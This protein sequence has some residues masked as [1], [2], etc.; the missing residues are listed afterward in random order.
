MMMTTCLNPA[1]LRLIPLALLTLL[2]AGCTAGNGGFSGGGA[3]ANAPL[4]A[5][6]A[7]SASGDDRARVAENQ[8]AALRRVPGLK[9]DLVSVHDTGRERVVYYGRYQRIQGG[10]D[11]AAGFKPDP[12]NDLELIRSLSTTVNNQPYWPFLYATMEELPTAR[13]APA[14]WDLNNAQ[15]HWSLQVAVFYN[16]EVITSRRELAEAYA[17]ELREQGHEAYYHHGAINSIVTVGL[18]PQ[19]AVQ[20]V[21]TPDPLTGVQ[22]ATS[23]IADERILELQKTFTHNLHNG[24][25]LNTI[26]RDPQTGEIKERVPQS[27]FLVLTPHGEAA[28]GGS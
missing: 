21:M 14:E 1:R 2:L 9:P 11:G 3:S 8:A 15:G 24:R 10:A 16:N 19:D 28:G 13:T 17:R 26:I 25:R 5:I 27:S 23:R 22:T 20:T 6:R 7:A 4:W 18:F 12:R